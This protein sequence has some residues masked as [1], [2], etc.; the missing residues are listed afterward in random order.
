MDSI[1]TLIILDKS[2]WLI[3][4]SVISKEFMT[5]LERARKIIIIFFRK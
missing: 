1:V 2:L 3:A 5:I 4:R